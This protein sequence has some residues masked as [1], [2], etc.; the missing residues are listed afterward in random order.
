MRIPTPDDFHALTDWGLVE[1]PCAALDDHT[2]EREQRREDNDRHRRAREAQIENASP[3]FVDDRQAYYREMDRP[4]HRTKWTYLKRR[5]AWFQPPVGWGRFATPGTSRILDLG[6][7]D[8]DQTQRVADFVAG[9]WRS[10]GYD[11]FPLEI[12]GVDLSDSRVENARRH[13][14]S[15]HERITLRF[16]SGDA[17]S[18][19]DYDDAF[20]DHTLAIGLFE[21]LDDAALD[22]TLNELARLTAHSVYVRDIL[23]D[24]PGLTP[25]PDLA[26]ALDARGFAVEDRHKLFEEPFVEEGSRDPLAVWPMNV[27]QLLVATVRDPPAH[28]TRY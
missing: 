6:C 27:H 7:G 4:I 13:T 12:V 21:V 8:G 3:D 2:P 5:K 24:Y 18:G 28:E 10:A 20:F 23:D 22:S 14:R 1:R 15:P 9:R 25:R 26:E 16:E 11:G 19:L 17:V